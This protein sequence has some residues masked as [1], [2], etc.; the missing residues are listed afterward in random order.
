[1]WLLNFI[2]CVCCPPICKSRRF[3]NITRTARQLALAQV[4]PTTTEAGWVPRTRA[5]L[6]AHCVGLD[7]LFLPCGASQISRFE[8]WSSARPS[9]AFTLAT[10]VWCCHP[11]GAP[12][13]L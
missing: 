8:T 13:L 12:L 7:K 10:A 5:H 2:R 6:V 3:T 4:H 9:L 11:F 1:M